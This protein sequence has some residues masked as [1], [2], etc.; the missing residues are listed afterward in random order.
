MR[1]P[2]AIVS[3]LALSLPVVPEAFAA[4]PSRGSTAKPT[5]RGGGT[6]PGAPPT[7]GEL[8]G[9]ESGVG[10]GGFNTCKRQPK[11]MRFRITLPEEA[12]LKDLISWMSSISCQKFILDLKARAGKVTILSPEP[13]TIEEAYAAFYASLQTMGLTVEPSGKYFKIVETTDANSRTLPIYT[14][15][16]RAP[17]NDRYVTQLYRTKSEDNGDIINVIN[18]LKT[19]HG[20]VEVVGNLLIMTDTGS[21]LSRLIKVIRQIDKS[22]GVGTDKVFFFQLQHADPEETAGI[23]REVFGEKEA[24]TAAKKKKSTS[25]AKKP[26]KNRSKAKDLGADEAVYSRVIVDE[27]TGT[28][29]VVAGE[30]DYNVIRRLIEQLDVALVGGGTG[31][32]HVVK[33]KNADPEEVASVLT[34]LGQGGARGGGNRGGRNTTG[35]NA[36]Q[37]QGAASAELFSGEIKVTADPA[38]RSLVI[39][40]SQSDFKALRK[41]INALDAERKQVYIEVYL[42]ELSI[43]HNIQGGA[44]GHF[45][46]SFDVDAAGTSGQG[47]GFVGS[48]PDPSSNSLLLSPSILNGIAAGALGPEVPGSG[49][50]LGLGRDIPAF[51]V[52]IQAVQTDSDVNL[53]A[54]PHLYTADN[55]EASIEVGRNVPTQGGLS[56]PGG[57]QGGGLVP[58]QSIQRQ[59]VTLKVQVTPHVNDEKTVTLDIEMENNDIERTD[60]VLGVT[61]TKRRLKLD[62]VVARDDQPIVLG[63][64]VQE[65]ERDSVSQVP[66]LGSIP[67]LGWLFKNK[68]REKEKVNLLMVL[69]PH[70][71]ETPD[72]ARRIHER[73]MRERLEFLERETA[74]KRRDLSTNVNYRKKSGLLANVNREFDRMIGEDE[75]LR[76]TELEFQQER[77]S[78]EIGLAPTPSVS[79]DDDDAASPGV[80]SPTNSLPIPPPPSSTTR[81]STGSRAQ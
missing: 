1:L 39:L 34:S 76:Q 68:R 8:S 40:A 19:K 35:Q 63:G 17:A 64:L 37:P 6:T 38:T 29:I 54:E 52:V 2:L 62:K 21:S 33:L 67:L 46:S 30:N 41:V 49:Q 28:L 72:D 81:P 73:R 51:G 27:R 70:I 18:K 43:G 3:T 15:G 13:V 58:V 53:V 4:P 61:T 42:L 26:S 23:V 59:D 32:I 60:P 22:V 50:F 77:I 79:P 66:G 57:G 65:V 5:T 55:Q 48:A 20:S 25:S 47:L 36:A 56:F 24:P 16:S 69:V 71:L 14:P 9:D 7:G 80:L 10:V 75:F 74:F 12:E 78:G 31:R 11:G 44:S 45:G